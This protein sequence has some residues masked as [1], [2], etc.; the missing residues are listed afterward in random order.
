MA[1]DCF[2]SHLGRISCKNNGHL[3]FS[4][5][6]YCKR[7]CPNKMLILVM[8]FKIL[9]V[10]VAYLISPLRDALTPSNVRVRCLE[11]T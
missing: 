2:N 9:T 3:T 7:V 4:L 1:W 5:S 8:L 10:E 6:V 11:F